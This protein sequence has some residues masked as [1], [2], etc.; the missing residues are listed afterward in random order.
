MTHSRGGSLG[1]PWFIALKWG[2]ATH[3]GLVRLHNEDAFIADSPVFAVADGMGGQAGGEIA[4]AIAIEKLSSMVHKQLREPLEL[5]NIV[6]DANQAILDAAAQDPTLAG[7]GT[8]LA[9]LALLSQR[10]VGQW[11][12]FNVGDSRVYR[13]VG[14]ALRQV[15]VDHSEAEEMVA[16]GQLLREDV[17]NYPRRNVIT[18]CLGMS[19]Q[20]PVDCELLATEPFERFI[21]CSDGLIRELSDDVIGA[22]ATSTVDPQELAE[23][24]VTKAVD[25]GGHDNVTVVV[26]DCTTSGGA[27]LAPAVKDL[28]AAA[29]SPFPAQRP[30]LSRLRGF[31]QLAS[32]GIVA[33]RDESATRPTC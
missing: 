6:T 22:L 17:A 12:V 5:L 28:A 19:R 29:E 21:V 31:S 32:A 18:R 16:A 26:V 27:L 14:G 7:M 3:T 9:G 30:R 25:A 2:A 11:L 8:T 20:T 33:R 4:A 23:L 24:L 15:T 10:G 13:L 1:N